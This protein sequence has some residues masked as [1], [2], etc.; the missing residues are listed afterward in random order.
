M[1]LDHLS[2]AVARKIASLIAQLPEEW[3][4]APSVEASAGPSGRQRDH[5]RSN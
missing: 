5:D 2:P 3:K 4:K 1:R